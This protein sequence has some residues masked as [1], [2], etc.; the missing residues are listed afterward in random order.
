MQEK[1]VRFFYQNKQIDIVTL[2][3]SYAAGLELIECQKLMNTT[4]DSDKDPFTTD[5]D[6]K[7]SSDPFI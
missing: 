6:Q 3:G 1:S 7:K 2:R 5:P 4:T